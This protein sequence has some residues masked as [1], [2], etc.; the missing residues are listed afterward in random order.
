MNYAFIHITQCLHTHSICSIH[1]FSNLS[2]WGQ[3]CVCVD[4]LLWFITWP[5]FLSLNSHFST[6]RVSGVCVWLWYSGVLYLRLVSYLRPA[7]EQNTLFEVGR[8]IYSS[9]KSSL[10]THCLSVA[11]H[12][13]D[14]TLGIIST[15]TVQW[16]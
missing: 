7:G 13:S 11:C 10:H 12:I 6:S 2:D 5:L 3:L 4:H 9:V 8:E 1:C 14:F 16:R 15:A